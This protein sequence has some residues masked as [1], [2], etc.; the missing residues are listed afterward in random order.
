MILFLF[1][2]NMLLCTVTTQESYKLSLPQI[3]CKGKATEF[4]TLVI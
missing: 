3:N 1:L 4:V 2:V